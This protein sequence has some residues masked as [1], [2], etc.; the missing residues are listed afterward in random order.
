MR[1]F[2][3]MTL[4]QG[5]GAGASVPEPQAA[6]VCAMIGAFFAVFRRCDRR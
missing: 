4:V 6:L 2:F 1:G 3:G 5:G